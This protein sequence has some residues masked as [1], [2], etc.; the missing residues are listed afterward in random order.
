M[1]LI[2]LGTGGGRYV[3]AKQLRASG[4][5]LLREGKK[6][7][8]IDPGPGSLVQLAK[9]KIPLNHIQG[10]LLSHLHLDHSADLSVVVD[11]IT[12]GGF[13]KRGFCFYLRQLL[14]SVSHFLT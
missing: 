9:L 12:E 8:L 5:L 6:Y 13:K 10:I 11:A 14:R 7:L 4:G 2:F 1:E 3:V